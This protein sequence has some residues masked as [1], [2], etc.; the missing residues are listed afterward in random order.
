MLLSEGKCFHRAF[1]AIGNRKDLHI[2]VRV[3]L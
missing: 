1:A 3:L 2:N